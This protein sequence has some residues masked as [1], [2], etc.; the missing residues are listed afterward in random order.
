MTTTNV[1]HYSKKL[2][3]DCLFR[4]VLKDD[5]ELLSLRTSTYDKLKKDDSFLSILFVV[6]SR[7]VQSIFGVIFIGLA[8]LF[9]IL[10]SFNQKIFVKK[11][12]K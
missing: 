5:Y 2:I 11:N 8:V 4:V 7:G 1:I 12:N 3:M 9:L 10:H 6:S